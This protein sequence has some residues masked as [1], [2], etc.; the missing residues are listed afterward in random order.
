LVASFRISLAAERFGSAGAPWKWGVLLFYKSKS[1]SLMSTAG[2]VVAT[3][4][5]AVTIPA[6]VVCR[7]SMVVLM[8]FIEDTKF[9][10]CSRFEFVCAIGFGRRF[11][12]L[13]IRLLALLL[14]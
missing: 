1:V 12:K 11:C 2:P 13:A 4:T 9:I 5:L 6:L 7:L 14:V 8:C 10:E 3:H